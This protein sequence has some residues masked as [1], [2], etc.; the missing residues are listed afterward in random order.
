MDIVSLLV[1]VGLAVCFA[2]Y[3]NGLN[4]DNFP[5]KRGEINCH[6]RKPKDQ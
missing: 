2:I 4:V 5:R 3:I 1:L 6:L